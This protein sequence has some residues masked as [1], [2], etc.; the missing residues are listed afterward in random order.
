MTEWRQ[1]EEDESDTDVL[2]DLKK[3]TLD[4]AAACLSGW[5]ELQPWLVRTV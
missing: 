4:I 3:A 2:E 1:S 5:I